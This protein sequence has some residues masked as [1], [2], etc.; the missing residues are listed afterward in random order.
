MK[1]F[2]VS[3]SKFISINTRENGLF[4]RITSFHESQIF[5]VVLIL[6]IILIFGFLIDEDFVYPEFIL[7]GLVLDDIKSKTIF[8]LN[9]FQWCIFN[10][11][12]EIS[13]CCLIDKDTIKRSEQQ[14]FV[15]LNLWWHSFSH[16]NNVCG[17]KNNKSYKYR[18]NQKPSKFA[19]CFEW[20]LINLRKARSSPLVSF[21]NNY[22]IFSNISDRISTTFI[23]DKTFV[24]NLVIH[25]FL[26]NSSF[27]RNKTFWL[28]AIDIGS[29]KRITNMICLSPT[30]KNLTIL[31][32]TKWFISSSWLKLTTTTSPDWCI[33][34]E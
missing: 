8:F 1:F 26:T 6:Y 18:N 28:T 5:F 15:D 31:S 12:L 10:V 23:H 9:R 13:E 14:T 24:G 29:S 11:W 33:F 21:I 7:I 34:D 32:W 25:M 2:F 19:S 20:G 16:L 4:I 30:V 27:T 22:S 17:E 3:K